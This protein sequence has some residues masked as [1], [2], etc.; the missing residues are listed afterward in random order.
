MNQKTAD[1]IT[2]RELIKRLEQFLGYLLGSWK[3]VIIGS[4]L[5]TLLLLAYT[6]YLKA[7]TYTAR[8]TFV[9]EN[10]GGDGLGQFSSLASLAGVNVGG[11]SESG[12]LFQIDNIQELY[13]SRRMI[14]KT[15][16][17]TCS[18]LDHELLIYHYATAQKLIEKWNKRLRPEDLDFAKPRNQYSR[19]QDSLLMEMTEMIQEGNLFVSKPSRK[20]S[21]LDVSVVHKDETLAKEFDQVLVRNVNEFYIETRTKKARENL[22]LLQSQTDSVKKVLDTK[23]YEFAETTQKLPNANPLYVTNQVPIQKL[24]IELQTSGAVYSE[25]V[26]NLEVSKITLR[27]TTPLIQIIDEP[28]LPLKDSTWSVLKTIVLGMIIGGLLMV[29]YFSLRYFYQQAMLDDSSSL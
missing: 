19:V 16:L 8:T 2:L 1:T 11:L 3:F 25:M 7:P 5:F 26:K 4:I 18:H 14:E 24:R 17:S 9:L 20:L 12:A 13:K 23:I 29:I 21:I 6:S 15:L 10:E 28:I 22:R 27:N